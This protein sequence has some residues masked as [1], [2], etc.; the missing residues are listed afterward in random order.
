MRSPPRRNSSSFGGQPFVATRTCLTLSIA[1]ARI[2]F[3]YIRLLLFARRIYSKFF[4]EAR[5]RS[6]TIWVWPKLSLDCSFSPANFILKFLASTLR[7]S[8]YSSSPLTIWFCPYLNFQLY[9]LPSSLSLIRKS[10]GFP[11]QKR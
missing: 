8:M 2:R 10:R 7:V 1:N 11:L 6:L 4:G 9:T 3:A 5:I